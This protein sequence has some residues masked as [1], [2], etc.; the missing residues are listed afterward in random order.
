MFHS[1]VVFSYAF[2]EISYFCDVEKLGAFGPRTEFFGTLGTEFFEN[3]TTGTIPKKVWRMGSLNTIL[4]CIFLVFLAV[5]VC[6]TFT[7]M[8]SSGLGE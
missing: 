3:H 7:S 4:D 2:S 5:P 6:T 8:L 1:T